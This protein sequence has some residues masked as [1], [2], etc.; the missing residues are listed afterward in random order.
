MDG[1]M[2]TIVLLLRCSSFARGRAGRSGAW[3][4]CLVCTLCVTCAR[5]RVTRPELPVCVR[6]RLRVPCT[7][8]ACSVHMQRA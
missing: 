4:S 2:A 7:S 5:V 6:L 1:T 8:V 3:T